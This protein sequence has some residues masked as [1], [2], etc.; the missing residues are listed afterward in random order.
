MD[1]LFAVL[2]EYK[3]WFGGGAFVAGV[4]YGVWKLFKPK[5]ELQQ[6]QKGG[7]GSTNIQ[8][9]GNVS[10]DGKIDSIGRK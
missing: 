1:E 6:T 9:G 5:Q 8:A 4:I 3:L 2:K 7:A 10:L